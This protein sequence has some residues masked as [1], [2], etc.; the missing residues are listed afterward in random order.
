MFSVGARDGVQSRFNKNLTLGLAL[1]VGVL[2]SIVTP[3]VADTIRTVTTSSA[4]DSVY[5]TIDGRGDIIDASGRLVGH[6]S[7]GSSVTTVQTGVPTMSTVYADS[8]GERIR[9]IRTNISDCLAKGLINSDNF[10]SFNS[11]L[12]NIVAMKKAC[13]VSGGLLTFDEATSVGRQL[14]DLNVAISTATRLQALSPMIVT[15]NG[16]TRLAVVK[17]VVTNNLDGS[18]TVTT[19]RTDVTPQAS[20]V[21]VTDTPVTERRVTVVSNDS[22]TLFAL[23]DSRR[24]ELDRLVAMDLAEGKISSAQAYDLRVRLDGYGSQ[25]SD[26]RIA[27]WPADDTRVYEI[28]RGLDDVDSKL[29]KM[30]SIPAL[31]PLT[32]VDTSGKTRISVDQFGNVVSVKTITSTQL[33]TTLNGR[34][35]EIQRLIASGQANGTM[36]TSQAAAFRAEL[37]RL[38]ALVLSGRSGNFTY[39]EALPIA[40]QLDA[41]SNRV[42]VLAPGQNV[43]PLVVGS[44]FVL[45]TGQVVVLDDLMVRRADLE[46]RIT[47]NLAT[48][49]ISD[50]EA[51]SLRSQMDE[52]GRMESQMRMSGQPSFKDSRRL[53]TLFDKVA[54]RLDND[55]AHR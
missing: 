47:Q 11:Q 49:R 10:N 20:Q 42:V 51:R 16:A 32:V 34:I 5:G 30:A 27:G 28:A 15:V 40:M 33:L 8:L 13:E 9:V 17:R 52:I 54:A 19:T 55:I 53:Y 14:D 41:L 22:S 25:L 31:Q 23:L 46:G 6:I 26:G 24:V 3:S 21:V 12:D 50:V 43:Q 2:A 38:T 44:R 35:T 18:Q 48:G 1:S 39:V 37:D 29:V 7:D 45:T 36:N 4:P